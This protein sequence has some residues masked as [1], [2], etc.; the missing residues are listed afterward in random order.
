MKFHNPTDLRGRSPRIRIL[1]GVRSEMDRKRRF[2]SK[3]KTRDHHQSLFA[4]ARREQARQIRDDS[5][6]PQRPT[7]VS[8]VKSPYRGGDPSV[9]AAWLDRCGDGSAVSSLR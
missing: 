8:A 1:A 6:A 9:V 5:P 2:A 7:W 3:P 4:P